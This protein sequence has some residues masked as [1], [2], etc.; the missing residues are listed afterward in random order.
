MFSE[1]ENWVD[2]ESGRD[3]VALALNLV[4]AMPRPAIDLF[5]KT[6]GTTPRAAASAPGRVNLIG[7]HTDY[8][9]G[10][11]LPIAIAQRT[12][13]AIGPGAPGEPG[14]LEAISTRD[15]R[16]VTLNWHEELPGNWGAYVAGVLRE[17]LAQEVVAPDASARVAVASDL[18]IGAGL[19]SSAALAVAVARAFAPELTS[20]QIAGVAY[21]AEHDHVGVPCGMMDQTIAALAKRDHALLFESASLET[22]Q[23][24][25]AARLLLVDTG[26]RRDLATSRLKERRAEC[27]AA[28]KR[29]KVELPELVWLASWPAAW[30]PRLKRAL[31]EP[32]RSRA[33]H[34]VSETARTRFA[35]ELLRRKKLKQF[36][37]LLYESHESCRRLYDCSSPELDTVVAAAKR[38]G[39][40]GARLTG[41]GWGGAA[42]VLVAKT[43]KKTIP[44]IERAFQRAYGRVPPISDVKASGGAQ[45]EI[46][47]QSSIINDH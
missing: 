17:L 2:G 22:T 11:V 47:A 35:A 8:N 16:L 24:P 42:I 15:S 30:L 3:T 36:G 31:R 27:E 5:K 6:F 10:P 44:A 26:S 20:R 4:N 38:A 39:A 14:V 19:S 18:P 46:I 40:W 41:A 12:T 21:R 1:I 28:V 43:D 37:K 7:E 33:V 32:L 13:A 34:V 23:I 25:F 29:L 9:G 45:T